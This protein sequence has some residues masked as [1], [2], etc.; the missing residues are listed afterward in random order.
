MKRSEINQ[1]IQEAKEIFAKYSFTL[2]PWAFFSPDEWAQKG[3]EFDEIRENMLGWDVTDFG[4]GD[5]EK[6]GLFLFTIRNGNY[7]KPGNRKTY[8]EKLMLVKNQQVTP[9]HFHWHKM[10]DI[11]NRA[12][13][14]LCIQ[15]WQSD[16]NDEFLPENFTIQ[17]DGVTRKVSAGEIIRLI[18][19][20]S[21]SLEPRVYHQ[22]WAEKGTVVV[23]EVSQVND[24]NTDNR[25]YEH[26]G[27]FPA[28]E[29]DEAP[30]HLLCNEYP[31]PGGY[32]K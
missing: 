25:F 1:Y 6:A 3:T 17:T 22:F 30:L 12:G 24:D 28:I 18:A 2:P 7:H 27:R 9:T 32:L 14:V 19:G 16:E 8:A 29:E 5:Y 26:V 4:L 13:G 20:E 21:I 15:I 10:E 23:G 11:I 31:E